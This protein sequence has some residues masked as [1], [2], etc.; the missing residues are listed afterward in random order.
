MG[1]PLFEPKKLTYD[2]KFSCDLCE[3]KCHAMT[4][5]QGESLLSLHYGRIHEGDER[6]PKKRQKLDAVGKQNENLEI[7]VVSPHLEENVK[8]EKPADELEIL[9]PFEQN[10][11]SNSIGTKS[12]IPNKEKPKFSLKR[13]LNKSSVKIVTSIKVFKCGICK[14][15]LVQDLVT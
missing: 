13:L 15:E 12:P 14:Q 2:K 4:V 5:Y 3:Y 9:V 7:E 8:S 11:I 6:V 10:P 1:D